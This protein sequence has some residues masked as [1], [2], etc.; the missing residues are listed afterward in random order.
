VTRFGKLLAVVYGFESTPARTRGSY[1]IDDLLKVD[2][3]YLKSKQSVFAPY[4]C[5]AVHGPARVAGN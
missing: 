4:T 5:G 1:R 2:F 3:D